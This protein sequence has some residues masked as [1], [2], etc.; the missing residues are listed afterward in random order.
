MGL[1]AKSMNHERFRVD[2]GFDERS[3]PA[4]QYLGSSG[5]ASSFSP[6]SDRTTTTSVI[7]ASLFASR[8]KPSSRPPPAN[9]DHH[10]PEP[11]LRHHT[12]DDEPATSRPGWCPATR[13]PPA[14]NRPGARPDAARRQRTGNGSAGG[15]V[16]EF[17]VKERFLHRDHRDLRCLASAPPDE[18]P[19]RPARRQRRRPRRV[20]P[21]RPRG[22]GHGAVERLPRPRWAR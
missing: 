20:R 10:T 17:G 1:L 3:M 4:S 8:G 14:A 6:S 2:F 21:R 13:G 22:D 9:A 18:L 5:W 12:P 11:T 7:A 15:T 19:E 16:V